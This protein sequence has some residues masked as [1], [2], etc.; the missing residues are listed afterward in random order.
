MPS[1]VAWLTNTSRHSGLVS[2]SNVTT[3]VPPCRASLSAPQMASLSL[4]ET[5]MTSVSCWDSVLM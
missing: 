5:T 1:A 4:A 2:E 3:L